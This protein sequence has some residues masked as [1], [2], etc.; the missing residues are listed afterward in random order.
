MK[1]KKGAVASP[2]SVPSDIN[3]GTQVNAMQTV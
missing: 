1:M 3:T 2:E